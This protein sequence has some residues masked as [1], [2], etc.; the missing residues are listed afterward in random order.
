MIVSYDLWSITYH[1]VVYMYTENSCPGG[2]F[3]ACPITFGLFLSHL[4]EGWSS[5]VTRCNKLPKQ[6]RAM[7]DQCPDHPFPATTPIHSER[8]PTS[9]SQHPLTGLLHRWRGYG[10]LLGVFPLTFRVALKHI[11]VMHVPNGFFGLC[12]LWNFFGKIIFQN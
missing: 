12:R 8:P 4:E 7:F 1:F 2:K 6:N 3:L 11:D 10:Q 5:K 9:V